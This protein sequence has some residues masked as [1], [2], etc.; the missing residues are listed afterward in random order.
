MPSD[1]IIRGYRILRKVKDDE[2]KI[3]VEDTGSAAR[4]YEDKEN[5]QTG[6]TYEYSV[7]SINSVGTGAASPA[8]AVAVPKMD[9]PKP[10]ENL[11]AEF[12]YR[13]VTLKWDPV[14]DAYL[15]RYEV[16][17]RVSGS[18]EEFQPPL[19][20][21]DVFGHTTGRRTST[22]TTYTDT[23][24]VNP[25]GYEYLVRAINPLGAG[26]YSE[27]VS[28]TLPDFPTASQTIPAAP[29]NLTA[30][31]SHRDVTLKWDT[32]HN[33]TVTGYRVMR[34][35]V[36]TKGDYHMFGWTDINGGAGWNVVSTHHEPSDFAVEGS[37]WTDEYG[38][39]P[40]TKYRYRVV[41][42]NQSGDSEPSQA[43]TVKTLPIDYSAP[44]PPA[45]P[46]E[47][48]VKTING[49]S[50]EL[51]WEALNDPS[52]V[53]YAVNHVHNSYS[54]GAVVKGYSSPNAAASYVVRNLD[55]EGLHRFTV[56]AVNAFGSSHPSNVVRFESTVDS[57]P[58]PPV[59]GD[60]DARHDNVQ[61]S[62]NPQYDGPQRMY[63]VSRKT[64]TFDGWTEEVFSVSRGGGG[65]R[66]GDWN[67][68]S[69]TWYLYQIK[70]VNAQGKS[71]PA[72]VAVVTSADE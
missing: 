3:H 16:L 21:Y 19:G 26:E 35:K 31:A 11:I 60:I 59:I 67:I 30:H 58:R 45:T 20:V 38:V 57:I 72:Y 13:S 22:A 1:A 42:V 24:V 32:S 12:T 46:L 53:G 9:P 64:H 41:A 29:R 36:G 50:A 51:S 37:A 34:K 17:R 61:I 71:D 28:V 68:R 48:R 10:P 56:Q 39:E 44:Q 25:A 6:T 14:D 54:D 43:V 70:V 23:Y 40:S 4:R 66:F 5:I 49:D 62:L 15:T 65:H 33:P 27:I 8:I 18:D 55:T 47:L 7:C 2:W 52:I 69:S 63:E